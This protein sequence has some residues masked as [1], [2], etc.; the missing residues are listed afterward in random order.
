MLGFALAN[1]PYKRIRKY[2]K[3]CSNLLLGIAQPMDNSVEGEITNSR[4][5]RKCIQIV[6]F[7]KLFSPVAD[8]DVV[9]VEIRKFSFDF[10]KT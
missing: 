6:A 8:F 5:H 4:C 7:A 9:L 2:S 3:E 10:M 1:A